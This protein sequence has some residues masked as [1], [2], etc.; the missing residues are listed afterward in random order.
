MRLAAFKASPPPTLL[1]GTGL[2]CLRGT[3]LSSATSK[4][5]LMSRCY[6]ALSPR[7]NLLALLSASMNGWRLAPSSQVLRCPMW[8]TNN[9]G[10]LWRPRPKVLPTNRLSVTSTRGVHPHGDHLHGGIAIMPIAPRVGRAIND[11]CILSC[12]L[13]LF[14][15]LGCLLVW[16]LIVLVAQIG[17][18]SSLIALWWV[19]GRSPLGGRLV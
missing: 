10:P 11:P 16:P 1:T 17:S 4:Q 19:A 8:Q 14:S 2:N 3:W 7:N 9:Y 6:M 13:W 5:E 15:C 12:Y 18:D